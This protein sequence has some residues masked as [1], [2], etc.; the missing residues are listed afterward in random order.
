[1]SFPLQKKESFRKQSNTNAMS[2]S[3][4]YAYVRNVSIFATCSEQTQLA[5]EQYLNWYPTEIAVF[6]SLKWNISSTADAAGLSIQR[7]YFS[8]DCI[9]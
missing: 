1:M 8:C 7:S 6:W 5:V 4:I 2:P 3:C 9:A